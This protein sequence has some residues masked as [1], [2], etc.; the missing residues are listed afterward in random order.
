MK[1]P[2]LTYALG[3]LLLGTQLSACSTPAQKVEAAQ[4]DLV[5]AQQAL[6]D[7]QLKAAE[8]AEWGEF[9]ASALA[10]IADNNVKIAA[11]RRKQ[12]APGTALDP[13]YEKQIVVFEGRSTAI[14]TRID[15][16]ERYHGNWATFKRELTHDM[17]E[18]GKMLQ[19]TGTSD[20]K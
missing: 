3:A 16:Y 14:Q 11:L 9:K 10:R 6:K 1:N 18:L 15:D 5:E 12:A 13:A 7:S 2:L 4:G 19:G 20:P 17:D 8:E